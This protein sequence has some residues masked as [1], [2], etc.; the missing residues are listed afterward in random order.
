[1][2]LSEN[3]SSIKYLKSTMLVNTDIGLHSD[4]GN[5]E[6]ITII[7]EVLLTYN[8]TIKLN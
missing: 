6:W 3:T 5:C 1:M 8:I 4:V 7:F 2:E